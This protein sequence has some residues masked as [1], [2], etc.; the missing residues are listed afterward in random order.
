MAKFHLQ[1]KEIICYQLA[2][3]EFCGFCQEFPMEKIVSSLF[4]IDLGSRPLAKKLTKII[5]LF[6]YPNQT[7]RDR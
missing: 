6:T 4:M 2:R 1:R 5:Q 7:H 3:G